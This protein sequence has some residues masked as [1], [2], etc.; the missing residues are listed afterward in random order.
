[1]KALA[2]VVVLLAL[3]VA[4]GLAVHQ[5]PGPLGVD[6]AAF[7]ALE[8]LHGGPGVDVVAV[9]TDLG[10]F[11]VALA[12]TAAGA[13]YAARHRRPAQAIRLVLGLILLLIV[14]NVT[15]ELWDRPRPTHMLT[16][17]RGLS[18]PSGHAAYATTWLAAAMV[19]GRRGLIAGAALVLVAVGASR[20]YL[21]VHYLSDVVG[22]AALGGAVLTAV[23][24]RR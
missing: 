16:A 3:H 20:L 5:H 15:K 17:A 21:H 10:A 6:R 1:M 11:P 22:G 7:D 8:P 2:L 12:V 24:V 23:L 14:V 9:L 4:L 19:T 13:L 18:F